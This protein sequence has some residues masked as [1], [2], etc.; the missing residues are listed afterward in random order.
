MEGRLSQLRPRPSHSRTSYVAKSREIKC[1][2]GIDLLGVALAPGAPGNCHFEF[3]SP[4]RRRKITGAFS[5]SLPCFCISQVL[6]PLFCPCLPSKSSPGSQGQ[7]ET[8]LKRMESLFLHLISKTICLRRK[9]SLPGVEVK[10]NNI[11]PKS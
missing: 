9:R 11:K 3:I 10:A 6:S 7:K 1:H 8:S 2:T 4:S 5:V